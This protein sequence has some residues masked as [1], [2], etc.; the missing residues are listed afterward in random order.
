[1][2][3]PNQQAPRRPRLGRG[4][5]SLIINSSQAE[6]QAQSY[7]PVASVVVETPAGPDK[8]PSAGS[9]DHEVA[10]GLIAPNPYQPRREFREEELSELAESIAR[11][12]VLQ[13]LIVCRAADERA[14]QPYVLIAGERRL[15]AAKR[16][17]LAKVPCVVR[18]AT[19]QEM[20]EWALVE[21][22]QRA[23]LGTM[24]KARA[25]QE[26][27]DRFVL[28]QAEAAERLGQSRATVANYLRMLDLCDGVQ[29][30]LSDGVLSFGHGKA[31]ASLLT[32]TDAQLALAKRIE[33][34]GLSVRQ[35]EQF[36]SAIAA[37]NDDAQAG[38]SGAAGRAA[39]TKP[40]YIL[41]AEQRLTE[42][43]GTRVSIQPGRAKHTGR[44]VVEYYN[45][46]D[47]DRIAA[48]LGV[49][50]VD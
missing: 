36:A 20:L 18:E 11:Q 21:N 50:S 34:E 45:L 49:R 24:E 19:A 38:D 3:T 25:Y 22:I 44:I 9:A 37:G 13:P 47:F 15:R 39:R 1:M 12:G 42:R 40:A 10:I 17:G 7:V 48:G 16:A 41:D 46:D 43:V 28:T 5:S 32:R 29:R 23:D 8:Q 4:L 31:L 6:P 33:S 2:A 14:E 26:Y 30:M 27:M 35:T